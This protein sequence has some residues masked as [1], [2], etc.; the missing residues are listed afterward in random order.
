MDFLKYLD[1]ALTPS[2]KISPEHNGRVWA[3]MEIIK[4]TG[5]LRFRDPGL[6]STLQPRNFVKLMYLHLQCSCICEKNHKNKL[7][8]KFLLKSE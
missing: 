2:T 4:I 5:F 3:T 6:L 7:V 1:C 8:Y